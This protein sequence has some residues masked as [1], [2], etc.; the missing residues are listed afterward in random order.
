MARPARPARST[1][2][3]KLLCILADFS[4]SRLIY[5]G[6][7]GLNRDFRRTYNA[8]GVS[9]YEAM[10]DVEEESRLQVHLA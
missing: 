5:R 6:I 4:K 1:G 2:V 9:M 7:E 8:A 10:Y 3:K